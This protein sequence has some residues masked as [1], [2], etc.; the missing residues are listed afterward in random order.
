MRKGN[1]DCHWCVCVFVCVGAMCASA[2]GVVQSC[3][4]QAER[5]HHV[6]NTLPADVFD[7]PCVDIC[8]GPTYTVVL[9]RKGSVYWWGTSSGVHQV[10]FSPV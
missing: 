1:V 10:C 3:S 7:S 8:A 6:T 5:D 2:D 4:Y 9:T